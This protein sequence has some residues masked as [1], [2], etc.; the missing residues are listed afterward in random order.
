MGTWEFVEKPPN[1]IPIV[2]KWVFIKKHDKQGKVN[3]YRARLMAEGCMQ[4]HRYD[5]MET[6]S[7]MVRMDTSHA[8]LALV[9]MQN[10]KVQQMDVKGAYLNG[11]LHKTIYMWQ[12]EEC[13]DGMGQV[14]KLVKPL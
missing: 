2:N 3:G 6:F 8:I 1:A 9:P 11:T 10:L 7:P 14:C 12:P 5:Y 13:E 4:H